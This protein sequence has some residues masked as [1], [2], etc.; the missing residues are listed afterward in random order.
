M[1]ANSA[2]NEQNAEWY[3]TRRYEQFTVTI[4]APGVFTKDNHGLLRNDRIKLFTS[5]ALPTGL[6]VDTFY[7]VIPLTDHTFQVSSTRAGSA[8]TTT[9]SQSGAHNYAGERQ[10][11]TPAYENNR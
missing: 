8:I 5:G 10:R 6:S 4:A 3:G 11:M 9:G 1:T 2:I 7:Y